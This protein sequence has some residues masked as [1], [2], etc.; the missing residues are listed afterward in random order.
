MEMYATLPEKIAD[1]ISAG[2]G[3]FK[4][5]SAALRAGD[6][7]GGLMDHQIGAQRVEI[8]M[9]FSGGRWPGTCVV[10]LYRPAGVMVSHITGYLSYFVRDMEA[11][12]GQQ[13]GIYEVVVGVCI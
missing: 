6:C 9:R 10:Q 8:M 12:E 2:K 13:D 4:T 5:T 1:R 7:H 3:R 11:M